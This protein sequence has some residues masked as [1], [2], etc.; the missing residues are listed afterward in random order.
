VTSDN[1][2]GIFAPDGV[3]GWKEL[4][5]YTVSFDFRKGV[6]RLEK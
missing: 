2:T 3:F 5:G 1:L 6:F 4:I